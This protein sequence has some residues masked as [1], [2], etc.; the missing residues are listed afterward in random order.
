[1]TVFFLR[2]CQERSNV[3]ITVNQLVRIT[4]ISQNSPSSL[5]LNRN[6]I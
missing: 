3:L 5:L 6:V 1:M 4:T 2:H